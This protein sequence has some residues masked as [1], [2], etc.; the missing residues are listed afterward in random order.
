MAG[1]GQVKVTHL[2]LLKNGSTFLLS[3]TFPRVN[4]DWENFHFITFR[5]FDPSSVTYLY[6]ERRGRG[7]RSEEIKKKFFK[8]KNCP[9]IGPIFFKIFVKFWI[10]FTWQWKIRILKNLGAPT[11]LKVSKSVRINFIRK[12]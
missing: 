7:Y 10:P 12:R 6:D 3:R 5:H 11:P 8:E 9:S 1:F 4:G 2:V